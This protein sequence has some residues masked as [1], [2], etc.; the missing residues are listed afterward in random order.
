METELQKELEE[1]RM[2]HKEMVD[3]NKAELEAIKELSVQ[4]EMTNPQ[5]PMSP[6]KSTK[7]VIL[8]MTLPNEMVEFAPKET[9]KAKK[10]E[11]S[12]QIDNQTPVNDTNQLMQGL[13][14]SS[15]T[16]ELDENAVAYENIISNETE[17]KVTE[18]FESN[19]TSEFRKIWSEGSAIRYVA[20][21]CCWKGHEFFVAYKT[22]LKDKQGFIL[23]R[24]V[25]NLTQSVRYECPTQ[26]TCLAMVPHSPDCFIVG[27]NTGLLYLYDTREK[28]NP[29]AQSHRWD[30]CHYSQIV[31]LLF[32]KDRILLSIAADG[33][34]YSWNIDAL[35]SPI[36]ELH[37]SKFKTQGARPTCA[38]EYSTGNILIGSEDG[39]VV[40]KSQTKKEETEIEKYDGMITGIDFRQ[41][42]K[43]QRDSYCVTTLGGVAEVRSVNKD[44]SDNKTMKKIV[45]LTE[46]YVACCWQPNSRPVFVACR[47]DGTISLID[48]M[49][50]SNADL[51]VVLDSI[52]TCC[53]FSN[54]GKYLFVG[55]IDSN[56]HLLI[57]PT[58][59]S[60]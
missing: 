14:Q 59:V 5:I 47:S 58:T 36:Q 46:S 29:V 57:C 18:E 8:S 44:S 49:D 11:I 19:N 26:P 37:M 21:D 40:S 1:L 9:Q 34:V 35:A 2:R 42:S 60:V 45:S 55:T 15:A 38:S 56:S 17:L 43:G 3:R 54:D 48:A 23:K 41:G 16:I 4:A 28:Q 7:R 51:N 25:N 10:V 13:Y 31:G 24:D 6:L 20:A 30:E 22:N 53:K 39:S 12:T 27:G 50:D 32:I 52:A 33:S